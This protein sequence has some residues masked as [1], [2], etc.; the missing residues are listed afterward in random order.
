MKPMV[1][2]CSNIWRSDILFLEDGN[3][4]WNEFS[5]RDERYSIQNIVSGTAVALSGVAGSYLHEW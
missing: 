5:H 4:S 2:M 1:L 3:Q